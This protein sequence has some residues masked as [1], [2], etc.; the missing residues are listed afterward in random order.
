MSSN[1]ESK[2]SQFIHV[3]LPT[4][5]VIILSSISLYSDI[6]VED[7]YF[8]FQRSGALMG[9]A[10]IYIGFHEGNWKIAARNDNLYINTEIWY[11]WLALALGVLGTLIWAYGDL[12]FK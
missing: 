11:Q 5:I 7:G 9:A 6:S 3:V 2:S 10:G 1:D 8:W 12:P 4:V